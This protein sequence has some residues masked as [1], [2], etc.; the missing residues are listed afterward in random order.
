MHSR[1]IDPA[2]S[3]RTPSAR[4]RVLR[5]D[6]GGAFLSYAFRLFFLC[7]AGYAAIAMLVWLALFRGA[8]ELPSTFSPRDWHIHEML[9]GYLPA[10]ITGFLLTAIPN[11]TGRL[12]V[13]GLPLL[14]LVIVW[15]AGRLAV[16]ASE[17]LSW[18]FA[19]FIDCS[20]LLLVAAA[21]AREIVAGRNW[22]NLKFLIPVVVLGVG[23]LFFHVEAHARGVADD[24]VRIGVA[25]VLILFTLIGGRIVPSFTRNWLVRENPGRLPAPFG[26]FE[27]EHRVMEHCDA[28][29]LDRLADWHSDGSCNVGSGRITGGTSAALGRRPHDA[30]STGARFARGLRIRAARLPDD[31]AF[32][33]R[34]HPAECRPACLD[35][36]RSGSDDPKGDDPSKSWPHRPRA[37]RIE[38]NAGPVRGR[39]CGDRACRRCTAGLSVAS[40]FGYCRFLSGLLPLLGSARCIPLLS[41]HGGAPTLP[42]QDDA[43]DC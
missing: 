8:L 28:R 41:G 21:A 26:K 1:I 33:F 19:A 10:V 40:P 35:G 34:N 3:K 29:R 42:E 7:G 27:L 6:R 16:A 9:Y 12:S 23:N 18:L 25:A 17:P 30:R 43:M 5:A 31:R 24:A 13:R 39:C 37:C 36:R 2:R 22:R 32:R 38:R 20:F 15:T 11:W 14:L 4:F